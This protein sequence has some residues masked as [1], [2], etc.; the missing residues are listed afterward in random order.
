M[1][2]LLDE[3]VNVNLDE[4]PDDEEQEEMEE[5]DPKKPNPDDEDEDDNNDE[6]DDND[7]KNDEENSIDVKEYIGRSDDSHFY[8]VPETG[9]GDNITDLVIVNQEDESLLSAKELEIA[10]SDVKDFIIR[11][12][13][14][15]NISLVSYDVLMKYDLINLEEEEEKE[16]EEEEEEPTETPPEEAP[17][18]E[19]PH[20]LP[21]ES[22]AEKLYKKHI[23][24]KKYDWE[25]KFHR[26]ATRKPSTWSEIKST[27]DPDLV[28]ADL[29]A[30]NVEDIYDDYDK[31]LVP[32]FSAG[33]QVPQFFILMTDSETYLVD[34]E[35]YDYPRYIVKLDAPGEATEAV[36]E[37]EKGT[38]K[39]DGKQ[40]ATAVFN[41]EDETNEFLESNPEWGVIGIDKDGMI[42]V[43]RNN[44]KGLKHNE[45]V[46][47]SKKYKTRSGKEYT[48]E[49]LKVVNLNFFI[50]KIG[51]KVA[52]DSDGDPWLFRTEKE[53]IDTIEK[54]W[55]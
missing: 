3:L 38:W 34:T 41:T 44:D 35:G 25:D 40:W 39:Q 21:T 19:E 22:I 13:H 45:A 50:T 48:V 5:E 47:E 17:S 26:V 42:H 36:D 18:T 24:E 4:Q 27:N 9:E 23:K 1:K 54:K 53:A 2:K 6:D 33:V 51:G 31:P 14:D 32:G 28:N 52:V 29:E 55:R 46:G 15:L 43:A 20:K 12:V 16:S 49:P 11:A 10:P 8:L 37:Y 7:N 30:F